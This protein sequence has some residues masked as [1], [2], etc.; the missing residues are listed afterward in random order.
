MKNKPFTSYFSPNTNITFGPFDLD[1]RKFDYPSEYNFDGFTDTS[2]NSR[3]AMETM[4]EKL[5]EH[6]RIEPTN[7]NRHTCRMMCAELLNQDYITGYKCYE[8]EV[9]EENPTYMVVQKNSTYG[10]ATFESPYVIIFWYTKEDFFNCMVVATR[11]SDRWRS[12]DPVSR[13]VPE[14]IN[15]K[16]DYDTVSIEDDMKDTLNLND[17]LV[18]SIEDV[19]KFGIDA[20]N[21]NRLFDIKDAAATLFTTSRFIGCDDDVNPSVVSNCNFK[22]RNLIKKVFSME[23]GFNFLKFYMDSGYDFYTD[24]QNVMESK[25]AYSTIMGV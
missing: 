9:S 5:I 18:N 14:Y 1:D 17:M 15:I 16:K 20:Y 11:Y 22:C 7:L 24:G 21:N 4:L 8:S 3:W 12:I 19:F 2:V 6:N 10:I 23:S 13:A 25:L